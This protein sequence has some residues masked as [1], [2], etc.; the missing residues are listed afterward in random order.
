MVPLM[1]PFIVGSIVRSEAL[2]D[3]LD[4]R[5]FGTRPRT[6][7]EEL[8]YERRDY[9]L[10]GFSFFLLLISTVMNLLDI[11]NFWAPSFLLVDAI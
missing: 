8:R 11:G 7:L 5:G 9:F 2:I 3:V 1:I 6:W 4:M 10:L